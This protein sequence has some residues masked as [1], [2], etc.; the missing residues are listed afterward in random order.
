MSISKFIYTKRRPELLLRRAS[1]YTR[2]ALKI[3]RWK[4]DVEW[5]GQLLDDQQTIRECL[6]ALRRKQWKAWEANHGTT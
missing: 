6:K 4:R 1:Q 3:A 2:E 5:Y